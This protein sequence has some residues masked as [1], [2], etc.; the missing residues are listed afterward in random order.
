[1][2]RVRRYRSRLRMREQDVDAVRAGRLG[3]NLWKLIGIAASRG[4]IRSSAKERF[5]G[6]SYAGWAAERTALGCAM[7]LTD[8]RLAP[9]SAFGK[10]RRG[11]KKTRNR[12]RSSSPAS[13]QRRDAGPVAGTSA[14]M[15]LAIIS[16]TRCNPSW[17]WLIRSVGRPTLMAT[18]SIF[19]KSCA[20][21][22]FSL[23]PITSSHLT[24]RDAH[25]TRYSAA[26]GRRLAPPA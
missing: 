18:K 2:C 17:R 15:I 4:R 23:V 6:R 24:T 7:A 10:R 13:V 26:T 14:A 16:Q 8:K 11:L 19:A 22:L 12:G 25:D 3:S 21:A 5:G 20:R 1:M 9:K